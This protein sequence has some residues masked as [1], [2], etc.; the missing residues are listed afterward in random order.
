MVSSESSIVLSLNGNCFAVPRSSLGAFF[1]RHPELAEI[2]RYEVRAQGPVAAFRDWVH[3][4]KDAQTPLVTP[5]NVVFLRK[6]ADEFCLSDLRPVCQNPSHSAPPFW[7]YLV[8]LFLFLICIAPF[9]LSPQLLSIL[10]DL[11]RI[12]VVNC[13]S[14]SWEGILANLAGKNGG[15]N[16]HDLGVVTITTNIVGRDKIAVRRLL[17]VSSR[18]PFTMTPRGDSWICLDFHNNR[19]QPTAIGLRIPDVEEYP[20]W[21]FEGSDDDDIWVGIGGR[22]SKPDFMLLD[23]RRY[24]VS[25]KEKFTF[26]RLRIAKEDLWPGL[27]IPI[28]GIEIYGTLFTVDEDF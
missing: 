4:L 16:L 10:E 21:I 27:A 9:L 5:D 13:P 7:Q 3:Y 1:D 24:D 28:S 11:C 20:S 26:I 12:T 15:Q 6:L 19:V 22:K 18:V 14:G 17:N 8:S 25:A 23:E 2:S